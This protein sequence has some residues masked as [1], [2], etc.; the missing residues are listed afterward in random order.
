MALALKLTQAFIIIHNAIIFSSWADIVMLLLL[1]GVGSIYAWINVMTLLK[2]YALAAL[3]CY[4]AWTLG[5]FWHVSLVAM[6]PALLVVHA[7]AARLM[8]R[9]SV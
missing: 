7:C 4:M 6:F 2:N 3:A 9:A 1:V 8:M 5:D